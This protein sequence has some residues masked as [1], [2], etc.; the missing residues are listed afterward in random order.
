MTGLQGIMALVEVLAVD[1]G[2]CE[3]C[4][5]GCRFEVG[6]MVDDDGLL[7]CAVDCG[8]HVEPWPD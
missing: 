4:G 6:P 8:E 1:H 3:E 7:V 5:Y 2:Y